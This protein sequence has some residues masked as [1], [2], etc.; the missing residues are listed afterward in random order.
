MSLIDHTYFHSSINIPNIDKPAISEALTMFIN[1]YEQDLLLSLLGLRLYNAYLA[2]PTDARFID[3]VN[4]VVY[5][6]PEGS[7]KWKGLKMA[8][9]GS[10]YSII[11]YYI[12]FL[13][14]RNEATDTTGVGEVV[15]TTSNAKRVSPV[16][17]QVFAWNKMVRWACELYDFLEAKQSV[18]PEWN[19]HIW[20][21]LSFIN[22]LNL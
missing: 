16:D 6:A 15:N 22:N 2:T 19:N 11:A 10:N 4:G 7:K 17:K 14:T 9:A 12:Y 5:S 20:Y 3:L 21:E 18:Y 8:L 1:E 13:W